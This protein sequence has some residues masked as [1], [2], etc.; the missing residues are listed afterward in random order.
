MSDSC[1][2]LIIGAGNEY[3]CD[4]SIGIMVAR[5]L[6][7]MPPDNVR[8]VEGLYDATALLDLWQEIRYVY[9][10]DAVR[11]GG[12]PGQIYRFNPLVEEMPVELAGNFSTHSLSVIEAIELGKSLGKLPTTLIVF[13]IEGKSFSPGSDLTPEVEEAGHKISRIIL[14]EIKHLDI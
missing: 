2:V 9:L 4:D 6:G 7:K 11:S 1:S 3:R 8:V 10:I 5:E 14:D 13:G 12:R